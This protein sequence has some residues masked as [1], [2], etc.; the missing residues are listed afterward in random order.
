MNFFSFINFFFYFILLYTW[1]YRPFV[2][3]TII[4]ATSVK[5]LQDNVM[6]LNLPIS[7]EIADLIQQI[8]K[9]DRDPS[10]GI[11]E[12]MDPTKEVENI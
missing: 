4:G 7:D 9:A 1:I 12:V 10:K 11:F 2:T 6:A 3:S 8:H 5:Q